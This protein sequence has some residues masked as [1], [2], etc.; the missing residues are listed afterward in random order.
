[1]RDLGQHVHGVI[2]AQV[3]SSIDRQALPVVREYRQAYKAAGYSRF[4]SASL[5]GYINAMVMMEALKRA[6]NTPTRPALMRALD[7]MDSYDMGGFQVQYSSNYHGG[8]RAVELRVASANG[9]KF[10]C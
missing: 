6:G 8:S 9:E 10:I 5:E 7:S 1:M 3:M 2:V 4:G